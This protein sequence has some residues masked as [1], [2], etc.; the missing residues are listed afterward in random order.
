MAVPAVASP[1]IAVGV[2]AV[3]S[4]ATLRLYARRAAKEPPKIAMRRIRVAI[5]AGAVS[6]GVVALLAAVAADALDLTEASLRAVSPA[7]AESPVGAVL[8]WIPTIFG[9]TVAIE[10]SYLG[11]FPFVREIRDL[12]VSVPT[13]A[14]SVAKYVGQFFALLVAVLGTMNLLPAGAFASSL[15]T[16]ALL[17][18]VGAALLA[19]QPWVLALQHD[20]REPTD[21]ERERI[22]GLCETAGVSPRTVRVLDLDSNS[23]ATA[24]LAGLPGHRRLLVTTD[25]LA[26]LDD[27]YAAAV[28]ASETGRANHYYREAKFA[29]LFAVAAPVLGVSSGEL[30]SLTGVDAA[31]LALGIVALA[32]VLLWLGRRLVYAADDY[33]V[34]RVGAETFAETLETLADDL[35]VSYESG[36]LLSLLLMRPPL[37]RRLDRL[38][39]RIGD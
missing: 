5:A 8:T 7:L 2:V 39:S 27:R 20:V 19:L 29:V 26:D 18:A 12:G 33:A 30:Q 16:L 15:S 38:R 25:L 37:G 3:L 4:F 17:V 34:D 21:A 11:A 23:V 6:S 36:R 32:V 9:V 22:A 14:W 35:A 28:V 10:A 13:A 1:A 31:P 24:T